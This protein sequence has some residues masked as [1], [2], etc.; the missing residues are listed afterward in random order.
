[1]DDYISWRAQQHKS[2]ETAATAATVLT[3]CPPGSGALR[4]NGTRVSRSRA[5]RHT[6]AATAAASA[7][8]TANTLSSSNTCSPVATDRDPSHRYVHVHSKPVVATNQ[9]PAKSTIGWPRPVKASQHWPGPGRTNEASKRGEEVV[10]V[11]PT[12]IAA[13]YAKSALL[14]DPDAPRPPSNPG[15]PTPG[16]EDDSSSRQAWQAPTIDIEGHPM[17]RQAWM[18]P[19]S[20]S[21]LQPPGGRSLMA[22]GR[23]TRDVNPDPPYTESAGAS[24]SGARASAS[25]SRDVNASLP[26]TDLAGASGSGT[27]GANGSRAREDHTASPGRGE[28][29]ATGYSTP[30]GNQHSEAPMNG[31]AAQGPH[32]HPAHI[33]HNKGGRGH[34]VQ[35]RQPPAQNPR[36]HQHPTH[37][38]TGSRGGGRGT[39]SQS[40]HRGGKP[41]GR[42]GGRGLMQY[43]TSSQHREAHTGEA[44][45]NPVHVHANATPL[46]MEEWNATAPDEEREVVNTLMNLIEGM[47][48]NQKNPPSFKDLLKYV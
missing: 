45:S 5:H 22:S 42:G 17:T 18:G 15:M 47:H 43:D 25:G 48:E 23:G 8:G 16:R 30:T 26:H 21:M 10:R 41:Q 24:G 33:P 44:R 46:T 29:N 9:G 2:A 6:T 32:Q 4:V 34:Q 13:S 27:A 36:H 37:G 40:G 38:P 7:T 35:D 11:N 14:D 31:S 12:T 28:V 39:G 19:S 20:S 3:A 1:M